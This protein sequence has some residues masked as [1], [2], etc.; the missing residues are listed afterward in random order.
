MQDL[1]SLAGRRFAEVVHVNIKPNGFV[2]GTARIGRTQIR[3]DTYSFQEASSGLTLGPFFLPGYDPSSGSPLQKNS[4]GAQGRNRNTMLYGTIVQPEPGQYRFLDAVVGNEFYFFW[5][6][7]KYGSS[8][9]HTNKFR[10]FR[11]DTE[12][13]KTDG[14]FYAAACLL[15]GDAH[16]L[17]HDCLPEEKRPPKH[18]SLG[19][20]IGPVPFVLLLS[21][22]ARSCEPWRLF[23]T[24]LRSRK[25]TVKPEYLEQLNFL[26]PCTEEQAA[27]CISDDCSIDL[28][29]GSCRICPITPAVVRYVISQQ[30]TTIR[31]R[32]LGTDD[33]ENEEEDDDVDKQRDQDPGEESSGVLSDEEIEEAAEKMYGAFQDQESEGSD[34][35]D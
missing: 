18:T 29:N 19:L 2:Q 4:A 9:V 13:K 1:N 25:T 15:V 8:F 21:M 22:L 12:G 28:K 30:Q 24:V 20:Q 17:M 3:F 14:T 23:S 27:M 33:G 34:F 7:I 31:Q 32:I 6:T 11:K 35:S 5:S 26:D 10:Y 16:T